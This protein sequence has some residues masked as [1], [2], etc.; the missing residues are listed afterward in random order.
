MFIN[1]ITACF[2][3]MC[4]LDADDLLPVKSLSNCGQL[5]TDLESLYDWIR[6]KSFLLNIAKCKTMSFTGNTVILQYDYDVN[7][8]ALAICQQVKGLELSFTPHLLLMN[9]C[10]TFPGNVLNH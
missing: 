4:L 1:D 7:H 8:I 9:I 10:T 2:S 5:Q 3:S 6:S